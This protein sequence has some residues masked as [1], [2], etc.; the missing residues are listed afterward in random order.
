MISSN[1]KTAPDYIG[2]KMTF[3]TAAD[4]LH[5]NI[6]AAEYN[7]MALGLIFLQYISDAFNGSYKQLKLQPED[8]V[9]DWY[10]EKEAAATKPNVR[11]KYTAIKTFTFPKRLVGIP[12]LCCNA[13]MERVYFWDSNN[14]LYGPWQFIRE[15]RAFK[16]FHFRHVT[17]SLLSDYTS[18]AI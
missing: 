2:L 11:N 14:P 4:K 17:I 9:S 5:S 16:T 1:G 3:W 7:C 10:M 12:A 18:D 13:L 6:N 8:P 15:T